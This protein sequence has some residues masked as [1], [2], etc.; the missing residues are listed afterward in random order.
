MSI[1]VDIEHEPEGRWSIVTLWC[2]VRGGA[3]VTTQPLLIVYN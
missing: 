3:Y 2:H 1:R